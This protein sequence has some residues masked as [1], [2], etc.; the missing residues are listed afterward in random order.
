MTT[1]SWITFFQWLSLTG[2]VIALTSF[3]GLWIFTNRL[4]EVKQSE[5]SQLKSVADAVQTYSDIARLNPTGLPFREGSGI[6]FDS[7]LSSELRDL[8]VVT[9]SKIHFKLG[10]EFEPKY[11]AIVEQFPRFP[12][13]HFALAQSLLHRGDP[14]WRKHAERAKATFEKSTMIAGH[15]GSHAEALA[16]IRGYLSDDLKHASAKN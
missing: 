11:R 13:G 6:R 2:S 4:E 14:E 1:S 12:F 3:I 10:E 8:Y 5:I 16:V 7:P 15:D 9:G